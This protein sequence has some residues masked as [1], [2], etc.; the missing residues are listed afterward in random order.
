MTV[1]TGGGTINSFG[2]Q[3]SNFTAP[4]NAVRMDGCEL[5]DVENFINKHSKDTP[6]NASPGTD[7]GAGGGVKSR[8]VLL[9]QSNKSSNLTVISGNQMNLIALM[10]KKLH[11]VIL[12]CLQENGILNLKLEGF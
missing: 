5:V 2:T 8:Y 6:Y 4:M 12:L 7:N 9:D 3:A 10:H 1:D 11:S